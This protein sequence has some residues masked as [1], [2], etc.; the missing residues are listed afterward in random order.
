MYL[1][2]IIKNN[3]WENKI[4][5]PPARIKFLKQ[6]DDKLMGFFQGSNTYMKTSF[7]KIQEFDANCMSR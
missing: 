6:K 7:K 4:K 1:S 5:K 3:R 2:S